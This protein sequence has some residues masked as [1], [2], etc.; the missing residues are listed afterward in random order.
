[1]Q[2]MILAAGFGTRLLPYTGFRPKPLFPLLNKPLL[3]LT[4]EHLQKAGFDHI[5]V[6]CHHLRAQIADLLQG[7][8]GVVVQE[9]D[10]ILGT[11]GGL[12]L[13]V[14]SLRDE[15][16]LV[17]N[18]DIYHTVDLRF[19]Y[20][21]HCRDTVPVTLVMHDFPRFNTVSVQDDRVVGFDGGQGLLAF[22]GLHVLDPEILTALPLLQP[23]SIIDLYR[24]LLLENKTIR[25]LRADGCYWTDMGTLEDYLSLHAGLLTG[26]VPW[27]PELG[28]YP[29]SS[30]Y[31][32]PET[33]CSSTVHMQD[34]VCA[35][36]AAIGNDVRLARVVLWDGATVKDGSCLQDALIVQV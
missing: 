14:Q 19:V 3:L 18:G 31:L 35:G 30:F 20:E 29:G 16:V 5:V 12:R 4:I 17:T 33:H 2:A 10:V 8:Q 21:S 22:T 15:P 23:A 25:C 7:R 6:N 36:R 13:A 1:M 28:P 34:W 24:R 9:E 27:W 32:A 11:G 26:T